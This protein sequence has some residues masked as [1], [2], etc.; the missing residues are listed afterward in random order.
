MFVGTN[1]AQ[2]VYGRQRKTAAA[3]TLFHGDVVN[4]LV[5]NTNSTGGK[6][7]NGAGILVDV[8]ANTPRATYNPV[9]LVFEGLLREEQR[10]NIGLY[11]GDA[12]NVAWVKTNITVDPNSFVA[13]D[14]NTVADTLTADAGNA[15]FLQTVTSSSATRSYSLWLAR[16]TGTGDIDLT[17][18]GGATWTTKTITATMTRY[19]ITQAAV[20]NPE[21][22][23]RIVTSGDEIYV[24]GNDLQVGTFP[25]SHIETTSAAITRNEDVLSVDADDIN[26]NAS[27]G[28]I[29]ADWNVPFTTGASFDRAYMIGDNSPNQNG[30]SIWFQSGTI[31]ANNFYGGSSFAINSGV[32][33]VGGVQYKT[34][35]AYKTGDSAFSVNGASSVTAATAFTDPVGVNKLSFGSASNGGDAIAAITIKQWSYYSERKTDAFLEEITT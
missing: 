22:G 32:T 3:F 7:T 26:Y 15:T 16:K 14:G 20:T 18:D 21:F 5:T 25:T 27:E 8:A 2:G 9:T 4:P 17:V 1:L 34:A 12:T 6:V 19:D 30:Q 11:S 33:H 29:V 13:P 10:I 35:H 28:T 24:W 31:R 23:I